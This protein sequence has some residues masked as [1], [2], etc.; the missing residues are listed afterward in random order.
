MDGQFAFAE[1]ICLFAG[2]DETG[3]V[4]WRWL[5]AILDDGESVWTEFVQLWVPE[6]SGS[7]SDVLLD[8]VGMA[9]GFALSWSLWLKPGEPAA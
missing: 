2:F 6:R 9:L 4:G 8:H 1:M 5:D 3:A 7:L